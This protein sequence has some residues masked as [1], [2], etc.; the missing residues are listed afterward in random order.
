MTDLHQVFV[1]TFSSETNEWYTPSLYAD[2][3]REVFG[4][5]IELDPASNH[6]ANAF[7]GAERYF[8]E[9]DDGLSR[10]W[11][12]ETVFCNPPRKV[13]GCRSGQELWADYMI[14]EFEAGCF[15]QGIYLTRCVHGYNWFT[16][17]WRGKWPGPVCITD[18]R[19][20]FIKPEWCFE[21]PDGSIGFEYPERDDEG[22]RI[23]PRDKWA[24]CFWYC[25][26]RWEEFSEVYGRVGRVI[27]PEGGRG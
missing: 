21:N 16:E 24:A 9:D 13:P 20:K 3:A 23:D 18:K 7:I 27:L 2:M 12:A 1:V 26:P 15:S 19:I 8:T 25:G 22:R 11:M 14:G 10:P 5:E 4:R 17:L 6:I